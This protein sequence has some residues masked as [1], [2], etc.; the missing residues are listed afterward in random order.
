[1]R[2]RETLDVGY[3]VHRK[4]LRETSLVLQIYTRSHGRFG[5]VARGASGSRKGNHPHYTEFVPY[6][7]AWSGRSELPLL[8]R[9]EPSG[10]PH[11]LEGERLFS[12]MYV[13]ELI[14]RLVHRGEGDEAGYDAYERALQAL[15][16][17]APIEPA[18]RCFEV[19]LLDSCGYAMELACTADTGSALDAE[20]PYH[21]V[22]ERGPVT[23]TPPV[24]HRRIT[25]GT[26]QALA[27]DAP[28]TPTRLREAKGLM[29]F[30]LHHHLGG[31]A[32]AARELFRLSGEALE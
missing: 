2:G 15:A 5:V 18:L 11:R 22:P 8:V 23:G 19:G 13:N 4:R 10:R 30:I 7:L 20:T 32:L 25:G 17:D 21:Y 3:V 27:G 26:L 6:A 1:M 29:R 16:G 31:R 24:P 9:A 28:W 14:M 12:A